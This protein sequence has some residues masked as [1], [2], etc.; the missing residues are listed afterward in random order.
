MVNHPVTTHGDNDV[1]SLLSRIAS[2]FGRFA[3]RSRP[4]RLDVSHPIECCHD[5]SV[6][7]TGELG[8]SRVGDDRYP[9]H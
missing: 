2:L 9:V 4:D 8:G 6:R 5:V 1:G 7:S 3:W